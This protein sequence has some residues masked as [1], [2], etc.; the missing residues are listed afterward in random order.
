MRVAYVIAFAAV[1]ICLLYCLVKAA[2]NDRKIAV[3][4]RRLL[5]AGLAA[6]LAN[7][8]VVLTTDKNIC[9]VA[10]S[11]FFVCI[12]WVLYYVFR[13]ALEFSGYGGKSMCFRLL[14]GGLFWEWIPCPC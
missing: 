5:G 6:V 8:V 13:F 11:V 3:V 9:I 2:G 10:Y 12:D 4:V 7:I 1:G 14:S